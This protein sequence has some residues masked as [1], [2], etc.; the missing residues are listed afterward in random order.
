MKE[1]QIGGFDL[2]KLSDPSAIFVSDKKIAKLSFRI[3]DIDFSNNDEILKLKLKNENIC[4]IMKFIDTTTNQPSLMFD[5]VNDTKKI[6]ISKS[7]EIFYNGHGLG[8][9][10]VINQIVGQWEVVPID[11]L[12]RAFLFG[13]KNS[14]FEILDEYN[15]KISR[16]AD[17]YIRNEMD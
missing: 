15:I 1:P 17:W 13:D 6:I 4:R 16:E 2:K 12:C 8:G 5:I 14:L 3:H 11:K 9:A 7:N 10:L